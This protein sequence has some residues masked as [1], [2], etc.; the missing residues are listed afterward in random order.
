MKQKKRSLFVDWVLITT[1]ITLT[2]FNVAL[3]YGD[4]AE[5]LVS[6]LRTSLSQTELLNYLLSEQ[7]KDKPRTA[8]NEDGEELLIFRKLGWV[9]I[10]NSEGK[11]RA[12]PFDG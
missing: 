9:V 12:E 10:Q 2:F 1:M 6:S 8:Y 4:E 11:F 3:A 7:E 5:P